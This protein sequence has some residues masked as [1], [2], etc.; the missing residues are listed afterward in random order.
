MSRTGT[1]SLKLPRILVIAEDQSLCDFC[2]DGLPWSGCAIEFVRDLSDAITCG[3]EP[4]VVLV[5]V[6]SNGA[7]QTLLQHLC[8]YAEAI[9]SAVIA[10]TDDL[11]LLQRTRRNGVQFVSR[12]CPPEALWDALAVAIAEYE[13]D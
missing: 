1:P 4:D 2:R 9:R 8:E 5:D 11:E 7:G 6:P 13:H 10:L 3:F 12:P